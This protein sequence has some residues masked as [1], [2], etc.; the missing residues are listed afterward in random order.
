MP[1]PSLSTFIVLRIFG[2]FFLTIFGFA[3]VFHSGDGGAMLLGSILASIGLTFFMLLWLF[4]RTGN[5]GQ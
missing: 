2:G 3:L 5:T 4:M 1:A